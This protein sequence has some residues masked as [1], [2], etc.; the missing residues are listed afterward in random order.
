M[1]WQ[2][3]KNWLKQRPWLVMPALGLVP[4]IGIPLIGQ[5]HVSQQ[6]QAN[7]PEPIAS[8][9]AVNL[10]SIAPAP[11]SQ[12]SANLQASPSPQAARKQVAT[13]PSQQATAVKPANVPAVQPAIN[14]SVDAAIQMRVLIHKAVASIP[15]STS[16]GAGVFDVQSNKLLHELPPKSGYELQ[17]NGSSISLGAVRLP[18][19]VWIDPSPTGITFIGD[20]GYRG[21]LL[22]ASNGSGLWVVNYV[23]LQQYLYSVV[24][25]EVSPSWPMEA[26]KAQAVAARS[27]ALTYHLKPV[28]QDLYDLGADE[29]FQVYKGI[30]SEANTTRRAVNSTSGEFVSYRGGVVESLYAATDD[31]VME[32]FQGKGMSQIGALG[33]AEQGQTYRQILGAY[34]AG[35]GIGRIEMD[36]E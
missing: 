26:L 23:N 10:P 12:G 4:L 31:I 19:L 36:I 3:M 11:L 5:I 2:T 24:G 7:S 35:T 33:L 9:A 21:R 15:V 28:K 8:T 25:S 22:I 14:L 29:Y 34:Y 27:Y 13:N 6:E 16:A 32:A 18:A 17:S 20:R 1:S 30:E